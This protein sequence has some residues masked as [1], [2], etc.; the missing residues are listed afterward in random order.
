MNRSDPQSF[1]TLSDKHYSRQQ[2]D[3][4]PI[5]QTVHPLAN[6][7]IVGNRRQK[8]YACSGD[9]VNVEIDARGRSPL[10]LTY[11]V[12][13]SKRNITVEI[14][15]GRSHISVPVPNELSAKSG[16]SGKF[17]IG[18]VSIE[19]GN[20]CTRRLGVPAMEV[21][22]DRVKPT[23]RFAKSDKVVIVEGD[24]A[25]APMRLTGTGVS[26][27]QVQLTTALDGLLRSGRRRGEAGLC[28]RPK[29]SA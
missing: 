23:A 16:K 4:P 2:L 29:Q 11:L 21:E 10:Q 3:I 6:V 1:N 17:S 28:P 7:D 14:P 12:T 26:A 19:D 13:E 27:A 24:V 8:L 25:K 18:L 5:E 22:V 9:N 20:G 15:P